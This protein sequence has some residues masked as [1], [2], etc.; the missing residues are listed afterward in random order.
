M[1]VRHTPRVKLEELPH[2]SPSRTGPP[3]AR[4]QRS[5]GPAAA[6]EG[7]R[8]IGIAT[9]EMGVKTDEEI[10]ADMKGGGA[11]GG[12]ANTASDGSLGIGSL[13]KKSER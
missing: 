5:I 12:E 8:C 6:H 2:P 4:G 9:C 7:T 11:N 10:E 3:P 1:A 13:R